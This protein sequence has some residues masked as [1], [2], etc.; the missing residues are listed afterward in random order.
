MAKASANKKVSS[1]QDFKKKMG[2]MVE[3]PS[4]F[5]VKLKNPGGLRAFM[6]DGNIPNGLMTIVNDAMDK[7][8]KV[9][10]DDILKDNKIDPQMMADMME[11]VD[12]VALK[13]IVDPKVYPVIT[14]EDVDGYNLANP[15]SGVTDPEELRSEDRLYVDEL[16]ED[17]KMYIFQWITGGTKDLESFRSQSAP[18]VDNVAVVA[19]DGNTTK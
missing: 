18:G 3:L 4:G 1:P 6:N 15:E 10:T 5:I 13:T 11:M 2:G 14:Q 8:K 16:P 19:I 7:G 12:S 9:T 17:D